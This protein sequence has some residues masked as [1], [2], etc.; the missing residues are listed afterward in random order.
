MNNINK[1]KEYLK[2]TA[3][4]IRNTRLTLK[5]TQR[6]IKRDIP[7]YVLENRLSTLTYEFRH[8]HIAY[9]ELR[10]KTRLQI[11]QKNKENNEPNESYIISL[12]EQYAWSP[13]EIAIYN[14]RMAAI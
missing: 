10:G 13:E 5:D 2:N 9:C 12:K 11:E 6:G 1:L 14:E 7:T 4:E 8:H 3:E